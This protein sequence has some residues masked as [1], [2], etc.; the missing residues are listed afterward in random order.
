MASHIDRIRDVVKQCRTYGFVTG[1]VT[2]D[3]LRRLLDDRD[4]FAEENDE[5][6]RDNERLLKALPVAVA[7]AKAAESVMCCGG[8][9]VRAVCFIHGDGNG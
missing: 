9:C 6:R 5:L 1:L 2:V 7:P 4:S 3:D 8:T